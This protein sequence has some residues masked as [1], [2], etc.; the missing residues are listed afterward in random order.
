M[1]K[2]YIDLDTIDI[3]ELY[4]RLIRLHAQKKLELFREK[5]IDEIARGCH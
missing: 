1:K 3:E 4:D 2:K 5:I